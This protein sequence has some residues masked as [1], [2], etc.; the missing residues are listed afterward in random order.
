MR[1]NA[2]ATLQVTLAAR[3]LQPLPGSRFGLLAGLA[4]EDDIADGPRFTA[5]G[6]PGDPVRAARLAVHRVAAGR[7]RDGFAQ[8]SSP[9]A[10]DPTSFEEIRGAREV[11]IA[12]ASRHSIQLNP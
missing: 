1:R 11:L 4:H 12:P 9:F 5:G 7:R 6:E 8:E 3:V 2:G 10:T